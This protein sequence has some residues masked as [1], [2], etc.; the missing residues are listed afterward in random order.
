MV[1]LVV[2]GVSDCKSRSVAAAHPQTH[3][4][5]EIHRG[6]FSRDDIFL[7]ISW[8]NSSQKSKMDIM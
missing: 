2:N 4:T 6:Y 3:L 5:H 8:M 1:S 7:R